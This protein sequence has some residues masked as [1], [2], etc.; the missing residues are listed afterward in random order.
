MV[1]I[2]VSF[3]E[4]PFSGAMLVLGRVLN[5]HVADATKTSSLGWLNKSPSCLG[6]LAVLRASISQSTREAISATGIAKFNWPIFKWYY[7]NGGY[8]HYNHLYCLQVLSSLRT[9]PSHFSDAPTTQYWILVVSSSSGLT[10][11]NNTPKIKQLQHWKLTLTKKKWQQYTSTKLRWNLQLGTCG[12]SSYLVGGRTTHLKNIRQIGSFPQTGM[13]IKSI[14]NDHP[15]IQSPNPYL[16][17]NPSF[18]SAVISWLIHAPSLHLLQIQ[19]TARVSFPLLLKIPRVHPG[20]ADWL[21]TDRRGGGRRFDGW[22]ILASRKRHFLLGT[23]SPKKGFE[24]WL[25]LLHFGG[26]R[27]AR[28]DVFSSGW[29]KLYNTSDKCWPT[30][31]T[32][33]AIASNTYVK[34]LQ[35]VDGWNPASGGIDETLQNQDI[36]YVISTGS[37]FQSSTVWPSP[38]YIWDLKFPKIFAHFKLLQCTYAHIWLI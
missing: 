18:P 19:R 14:W 31:L 25:F 16:Q 5:P 26:L 36:Q 3:W 22:M 1:G 2:L 11:F 17:R 23:N 30:V 8:D 38:R 24:R 35:T 4:G 12:I 7:Q 37:G 32:Y 6:I 27:S 13:K 34:S 29:V 15:D 10:F 9:S 20:L 28:N 21:W 33:S